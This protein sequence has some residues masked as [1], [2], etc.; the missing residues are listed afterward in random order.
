MTNNESGFTLIEVLVTL[1]L[2]AILSSIAISSPGGMYHRILLKSTAME[3][4]AALCLSRQLSLDESKSYCVELIRDKYKVTEDVFGGR[5]VLTQ[6]FGKGISVFEDSR[7]V[8][9]Y[10]RNGETSYGKFI[11][12][13]KKGQKIDIEILIGTA[14]I[15]ISDIY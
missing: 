1:S 7:S 2:F 15:K 12:I 11:L 10:N 8:I 5:V 4:K 14:R 6:K 3:I 13:N 9:S